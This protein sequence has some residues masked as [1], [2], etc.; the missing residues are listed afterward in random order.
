MLFETINQGFIFLY[1]LLFCL[2]LTILNIPFKIL[3]TKIKQKWLVAVLDFCCAFLAS[4]FF[5]GICILFCFGEIRLYAVLTYI[6]G[7]LIFNMLF[8]KI[9]QKLSLK[10]KKEC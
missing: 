3:K 8:D 2:G 7:I 5:F 1:I 6:F 4:I 10:K 9:K